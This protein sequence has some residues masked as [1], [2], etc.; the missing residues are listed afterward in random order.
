[1]SY[2]DISKGLPLCDKCKTNDAFVYS[3]GV[4]VCSEC[5]VRELQKQQKTNPHIRPWLEAPRGTEH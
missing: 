3:G 1:M 2:H 4:F 5:G